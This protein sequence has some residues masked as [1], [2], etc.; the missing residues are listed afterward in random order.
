MRNK[1]KSV[2]ILLLGLIAGV[3]FWKYPRQQDVSTH[4]ATT[5][6]NS[7]VNT[8]AH[9]IT[10]TTLPQAEVSPSRP[11]LPTTYDPQPI[12]YPLHTNIT[13]TVFWVG[14]PVGNGSSEDNNKCLGR[15]VA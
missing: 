12:T 15:H 14:E 3:V 10:P 11:N 8:G 13:A 7:T 4:P 2:F 1:Q 5:N 6:N 9:D